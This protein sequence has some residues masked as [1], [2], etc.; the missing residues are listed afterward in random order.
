MIGVVL[1]GEKQLAKA[2]KELPRGVFNRV[3]KRAHV[4]AIAPVLKM[5]K[6]LVPI[7]YGIL[8]RSLGAKTKVYRQKGVIFTAVGARIGFHV[9]VGSEV[10]LKVGR[11]TDGKFAARGVKKTTGVISPVKYAHL[12]EL[13]HGGPHPAPPHPFLRPAFDANKGRMLETLKAE[14]AAGIAREAEKAAG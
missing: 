4:R 5:A 10:K 2:L 12:V 1:Q 13:G 3:L 7:R 8:K 6:Q 9:S 11:G 14:L